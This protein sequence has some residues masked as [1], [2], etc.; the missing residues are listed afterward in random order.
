MRQGL[1]QVLASSKEQESHGALWSSD[2]SRE[3]SG[4]TGR[5]VNKPPKSDSIFRR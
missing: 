2:P 1:F 5:Q 3:G 4:Q